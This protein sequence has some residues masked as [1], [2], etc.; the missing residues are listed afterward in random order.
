MLL[1]F[2]A[3]IYLFVFLFVLL[4]FLHLFFIYLFLLIFYFNFFFKFFFYNEY[5]QAPT[6]LGIV[7]TAKE[8]YIF[9]LYNIFSYIQVP[10]LGNRHGVYIQ[11]KKI[12]Q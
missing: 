4:L 1:C 5:I 11:Q 3:L 9:I 6:A 7:Y 2:N 10:T 12:G 8:I